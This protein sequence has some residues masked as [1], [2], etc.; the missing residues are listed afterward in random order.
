[1]SPHEPLRGLEVAIKIR[2]TAP[3]SVFQVRSTSLYIFR[4][5]ASVLCVS[6]VGFQDDAASWSTATNDMPAAHYVD[7]LQR[8][9]QL[10]SEGRGQEA[11]SP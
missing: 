6:F 5:T 9:T 10:E 4:Q 1:M 11:E 2:P 7:F 8:F 3:S